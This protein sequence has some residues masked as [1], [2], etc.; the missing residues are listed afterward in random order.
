VIQSNKNF[1][2]LSL[3]EIIM[4]FLFA[5]ILVLFW[6]TG[7]IASAQTATPTSPIRTGP[8]IWFD[9][10]SP[11]DAFATFQSD[12]SWP[13]AAWHTSVMALEPSWI[14]SASDA[15]VLTAA[16]FVQQHHM[17]LDL[18][19]QAVRKIPGASCGGI[20]GYTFYTDID[21]ILA[22]LVRLGIRLDRI[23]M[24]EPIWF[25]HYDTEPGACQLAVPDLVGRVAMTMQDITA[26]YP[27]I[28]IVEIEPIPA[29]TD[30]P[31][32]KQTMDSFQTGFFQTTGKKI[33]SVQTDTDWNNPGWQPA[34]TQLDNYLR[35]RNVG[36]GIL[37][38]ATTADTT[39][40]AWVDHAANNFD[41]LEGGL[42]IIPDQAFFTTWQPNPSRALPETSPN[43]L[44]GLIDRYLLE[45]TRLAVEFVGQG[46][47]GKLT[48]RR[49]RPIA[50]ATV[51]G[52]VP[53]VDFNQ[54][55]P[56]TV[57][58]GTVPPNATQAII[59]FRLNTE[60]L[61]N[62]FNDILVGTFQ[63]QEIQGGAAQYSWMFP[64]MSYIYNGV[65]VTAELVDG[66]SVTRAIAQPGQAFTPNSNIFPVTPG[67]TFQYSAPAGTIGGAGW[68][69]N[70]ILIWLTANWQGI[71]RVTIVPP[72]SQVTTSTATTAA[73]G[74]FALPK[75][76]RV[77]P[78]A[79]P[80]SV[81]FTATS[82]YRGSTWFPLQ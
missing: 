1:N 50:N 75:L 9:P 56:V 63:Y 23:H 40:A 47:R 11:S 55:L 38:T 60:C 21:L 59:G 65:V 53:G 80:V 71:G 45:R 73:D 57:Y 79:M 31:D 74:T 52:H 14:G 2:F 46:A 19:V 4:R 61:C 81:Q 17:E 8:A 33:L 37:Y 42:G 67:A 24:D 72:P 34:I 29:L 22:K 18:D 13:I 82:T 16:A 27:D 35:R 6:L 70:I 58:Q 51:N 26:A 30:F 12:A 3:K 10:F 15:D 20:E 78:G 32:W 62:G 5:P 76:P 39:D 28:K 48:T 43:T 77:G 41:L 44:T 36:L 68:Y 7:S 49:G 25:G 64:N 66:T 54:P 69:G